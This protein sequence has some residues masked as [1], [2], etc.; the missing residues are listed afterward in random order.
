MFVLRFD[1]GFVAPLFRLSNSSRSHARHDHLDFLS[2]LLLYVLFFFCGH[3][4]FYYGACFSLGVIAL[5]EP[6]LC[7]FLLL[8]VDGLS[9]A[10]TPLFGLSFRARL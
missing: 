3:G 8:S 10:Q 2:F 5:S 1:P 7:L 9:G 6:P 4:T